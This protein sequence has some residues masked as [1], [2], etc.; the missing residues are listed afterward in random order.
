MNN[1]AGVLRIRFEQLDDSDSLAEAILLHRQALD[2]CLPGHPSRSRS[3]FMLAEC[4]LQKVSHTFDFTNGLQHI[5]EAVTD[6]TASARKRL[7]YII[8]ILDTV[9]AGYQSLTEDTRRDHDDRVLQIYI[10]V[11]RLLPKAASF[12]QDHNARLR[13]LVGAETVSRNAAARGI[14]AKRYEEAVEILEEGRGVFW[15][16]ALRLRGTELDLLP[17]DEAQKLKELFHILEAGS[18]RNDTLTSPQQERE[19]EQ[20]RVRSEAAENIITDIRSRPGMKRF[21]MPPAFSSLAQ[22]L[23]MGFVILLNISE[24]GQHALV[25]GGKAGSVICVSLKLPSRI[26]GSKRGAVQQ[27]SSRDAAGTE[28]DVSFAESS[29]T[30]EQGEESRASGVRERVIPTFEDSL[31]DLWSFIVKPIIDVLQLKV[32]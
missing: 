3:L 8:R 2:L 14:A 23:S 15:A 25:M 13:E 19:A 4:M 17:P 18:V 26:S 24:L 7:H 27:K 28:V 31:A 32:R 21:L 29:V 10:L 20:R 22:L 16:Q 9:E 6:S 12:G 5:F 1:L 30:V 11:I